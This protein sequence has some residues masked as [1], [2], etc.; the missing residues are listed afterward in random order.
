MYLNLS[1]FIMIS[2]KAINTDN[3]T[4]VDLE[5]TAFNRETE[6]SDDNAVVISFNVPGTGGGSI[7]ELGPDCLV[8]F[9][10]EAEAIRRLFWIECGDNKVK[11]VGE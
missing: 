1:N 8:F 3:I 10:G 2:N 4:H 7:D 5:A 6:K 11:A 9:G